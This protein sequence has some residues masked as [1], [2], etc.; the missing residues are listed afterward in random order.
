MTAHAMEGDRERCLEAGMDAY[1]AKPIRATDLYDTL[2]TT[3][4]GM[5][6]SQGKESESTEASDLLDRAQI[7]EQIGGS[8]ETLKEIVELFVVESE[9]LMKAIRESIKK[10]DSSALQRAAHTLKGSV[11]IFRAERVA[12]AALRLEKAG[13]DKNLVDIEDD[14]TE[15]A[16]ELEILVP[17]LT[18]LV[19]S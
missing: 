10:G 2:E 6:L 12:S 1:I 4:A 16:R 13:K 7:L 3:V 8:P 11:R 15:L 17:M 19:K 18:Q 9:R 14:L 5:R